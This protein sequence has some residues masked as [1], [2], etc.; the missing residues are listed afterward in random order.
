VGLFG[1]EAVNAFCCEKK[2][3][4]EPA[5]EQSQTSTPSGRL[6]VGVD[7]LRD[8]AGRDSLG[9]ELGSE[10]GDQPPVPLVAQVQQHHRE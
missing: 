10:L 9:D 3:G 5:L 7:R 4:G 2:Q 8:P 1:H 6:V